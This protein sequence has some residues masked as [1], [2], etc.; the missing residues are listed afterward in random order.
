MRR[1]PIEKVEAGMI[2]A[3]PIISEKG[4]VLCSKGSPLSETLIGRLRKLGIRAIAV[5][6][7]DPVE[8]TMDPVQSRLEIDER[9]S[10][11][12]DDPLMAEIKN[13]VVKIQ[14]GS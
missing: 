10:K 13:L 8:G 3:Q 6:G 4:M 14:L 7:E 11:V 9:F 12:A 1:V 2:T 5:E